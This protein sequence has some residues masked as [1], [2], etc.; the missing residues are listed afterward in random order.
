MT[1]TEYE[2]AYPLGSVNI[3]DGDTVRPMTDAEWAAWVDET[4]PATNPTQAEIDAER[5][6]AYVAESDPLFFKWQRSE[7]TEQAWLDKVAEIQARYPD[8]AP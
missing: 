8:P 1:K 2:A 7:N 5:H 4:W 3:Q 6:A